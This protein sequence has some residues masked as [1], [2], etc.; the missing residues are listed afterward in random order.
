MVIF[1]FICYV[2]V[3]LIFHYICYVFVKDGIFHFICYLFGEEVM[4]NFIFH[5]FVEDVMQWTPGYNDNPF[6]DWN[7][8]VKNSY[9]GT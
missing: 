2:F 9:G 3:E 6:R 7:S 5:V 4:F 1:H 8:I